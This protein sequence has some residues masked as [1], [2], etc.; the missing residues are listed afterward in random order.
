MQTR[1]NNPQRPFRYLTSCEQTLGQVPDRGPVIDTD[2]GTGMDADRDTGIGRS[3]RRGRAVIVAL[4]FA[5]LAPAVSGAET[6]MAG[7]LLGS[8]TVG[9]NLDDNSPGSAEAF[10]AAATTSGTVSSLTVY[11][12]A[13]S[14]ATKV[15]AGLYTE[16]GGHPGT[17][18]TQGSTIAPTAGAWNQITVPTAAVTAGTKYWISVLGPTGT[19]EIRFRDTPS[20][21]RSENSS[22][23]NLTSL[24]ATWSPGHDWSNSPISA[25]ASGTVSTVPVLSVSPGSLS[26]SAIVGGPNPASALLSVSN[27]GTGSLSFTA[28]T[29]TS[30]LSVSPS[31]ASTPQSLSVF[32]SIAGLAVGTYTGHVTVTAAGTQGSPAVIAVTLTVSPAP[33]PNSGDWLTGDH[34]AGRSGFAADETSITNTNAA[35][36][37]HAWSTPLD[38]KITA[39]PLYASGVQVNGALHDVVV[40][41][42]DA[43]SV[44]AVDAASGAV[45]WRHNF[46]PDAVTSGS[47][48]AIPGGFGIAGIPVIDRQTRRVYTVSDDGQLRVLSLADGSEAVPATPVVSGPTTN[49]VWGALQLFNGNLYIPTG[50]DGGDTKPWRGGIYQVNV[51]GGAPVVIKH[52]VT[53]PSVPEPGGGGGIWGYG[54]VSVDS[55]TGHV[56]ATTADDENGGYTDYADRIIALD[57]NLNLLG[58][59]HPTNP[60]TFTCASAPCDLDFAAT[61]VV[62]KPSGCPAMVAAGSK[63]GNLYLMRESDLESNGTPVQT[64]QLNAASDGPGTGGVNG[65]PA[66]WPAGRMLF[67]GDTGPGANGVAAGLVGLSIQPDCTLKV[68]WSQPLGGFES[69]NS[70]PTVANGVVF[71]GLGTGSV[72]AFDA[73]SGT[74]LWNSGAVGAA[75]YGAPIVANGRV[76]A[77][78]WNEF[79][80][81][82]GGTLRAFAIPTVPGAPTGVVA[83]A[84]NGSATVT[85]TAPS[86]GGSPITSYT[87]T[88][89]AGSTAP[90]PTTVTGSPPAT[91]ATIGGLT[92]GAT[93]TFTVTATNA[94]GTG[95]PSTQSNAVTPI[96]APVPAFVQQASAHRPGVASLAVTPAASVTAGD[97]LVVEVGVWSSH[98]ATAASVTDSA[99]NHYVELLHFR[100]AENTEMSVWTAP[101]TAGGGTRPTI[102]VTPTFTADTGAAVLEYSGLSTVADATVVDQMAYA[103]G[104]TGAAGSVASGPT[105]ATS[106]SNE[107]AMGFYVDSG[108]GDSLAADP[109]YAQRTNV[110]PTGEMEFVAE[111][112]VVAAG[113][114]PNATVFTGPLTTWLMATIVFKGA[115]AGP[116][117]PPA[118]PT[119][120][121]ASAGNGNATVTWTAP[122]NGG[123][124]I[125]SY[126]VTPYVGSTAQ[127]A[128]TVTGSPP[129]TSATIGGLTNGTAYTFTVTAT[130]AIGTGP[131]STQS[132]AVTPTATPAGPVID[133]STPSI[134]AV[135]N[136]VATVV[137]NSFS[138]P[139]ASIICVAFA[140]DSLPTEVNAHVASVTNNGSALT[141]HLKGN[142][143]HV[144]LGVGGFVE[145]W[146]AYNPTSQTNITV[147][148]NLAQLTKNVTPPIGALQVIVLRNA[149]PDQSSAAWTPTWDVNS[150]SAPNATVTTTVPNSL[151]FAVA[152]NWDTSEAPTV[153]A[154]QT[155]TVN[156]LAATVLNPI[157][158]DTYWVQVKKAPTAV[159]GSVT[160]SDS[161]PSVRYHMIAWEVLAQQ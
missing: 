78:S 18:L 67:V 123:S 157:D 115:A 39:Q 43:N 141:W 108:F 114:T 10:G 155:T 139:A 20:G 126:T 16:N 50:S 72:R 38:G 117:S 79:S 60:I 77:G 40:T 73:A 104:L 106:A 2:R 37:S 97:R 1:K 116:P 118:A 9:G 52:W 8:Q 142:E 132:N 131:P 12:D 21:S 143:N 105:A 120:V 125:T 124:P 101:V 119:G 130:N 161:A 91:S 89:Y 133:V 55:A 33:P 160:M 56:Y 66:Y 47:N 5:V 134:T 150:G 138:P 129:T 19:G 98:S 31:S 145:V 92:N 25:Y 61:P 48:W 137:S 15:V 147:T 32:A 45:L 110:S 36:L 26:M 87:V 65:V 88:P 100:A 23:T 111:D 96:A 86:N 54:G 14:K 154:D 30:W 90:A 46:G 144:G 158:L 64:L 135:P 128:T 42:T 113:A 83:T 13:T 146:W 81:S 80:S 156:G 57:S 151:V 82:G 6:A 58:S 35:N 7:V 22:Q 76:Y 153:P 63:N 122:S 59:F 103:T 112:R 121:S 4:V 62:F 95:P 136:N 53:T 34:D 44:Y 102:T 17:L 109:T 152:N 74:P 24:P 29:D 148:G 68:A 71:L 41:A 51:T 70:T 84:G 49:R 99:G 27:S 127:A 75:V 28:A 3:G 11:L 140:L 149:A 85:W 159:A 94:I 107:L 69:P 93:Y